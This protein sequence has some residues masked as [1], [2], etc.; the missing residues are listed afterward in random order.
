[1]F[2]GLTPPAGC[3]VWAQ[4]WECEDLIAFASS[5]HDSMLGLCWCWSYVGSKLGH[6]GS[7]LVLRGDL[8]GPRRLMFGQNSS[9]YITR[10]TGLCWPILGLCW[11]I[12]GL[13]WGQVRPFWVYVGAVL[14][15]LGSMLGPCSSILGLCWASAD[16]FGPSCFH[17]FIFIPKFCLKKLPP[18]ACEAQ[19]WIL[20]RR[21]AC[22][23]APP[24]GL[25]VSRFERFFCSHQWPASRRCLR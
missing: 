9:A 19:V 11:P 12:C 18:V 25:Q 5:Y 16:D 6:V 20:C 15:H 10:W 7:M 24:S 23:L 21:F 14:A 13:C 2:L 22:F 8:L 3:A 4:T 17:D 1:M